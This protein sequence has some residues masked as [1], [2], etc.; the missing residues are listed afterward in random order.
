MLN[1]ILY[2]NF[3]NEIVMSEIWREVF[4]HI[5]CVQAGKKRYWFILLSIYLFLL[6]DLGHG[7]VGIFLFNVLLQAK[8]FF[9][10]LLIRWVNGML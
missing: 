8:L 10:R 1:W 2:L 6:I 5:T 9:V 7:Y 3:N 4:N